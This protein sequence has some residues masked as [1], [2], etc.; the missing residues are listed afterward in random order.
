MSNAYPNNRSEPDSFFLHLADEYAM[1]W[2]L[3]DAAFE[4][5]IPKER[6]RMNLR[7]EAKHRLP[8]GQQFSKW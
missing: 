7:D 1:P 5:T 4:F 8:S 6:S 2:D 3:L